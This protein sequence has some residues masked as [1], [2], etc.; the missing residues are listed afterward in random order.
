[1]Q[2]KPLN[3]HVVLITG[4]TQGIGWETAKCFAAEG[5]IVIVNGY[6]H[7]KLVQERSQ[8]LNNSYQ[9]ESMPLIADFSDPQ[10]IQAAYQT[11]YQQYKRLDIVVNNAGIMQSALLGMIDPEMVSTSLNLNVTGVIYSMQCAARL[12]RRSNKKGSIINVSSIMGRFG[13]EGQV[14]YSA[15]K[16]AV[17]GATMAAAKELASDGIR[18][19]CVAPGM[20][21]T[22]LLKDLS[23]DNRQKALNLIRLG[24]I[25]TPK[26]I[27]DAILFL[28]S[29]K[30]SYITGQTL[31]ID[32]GMAI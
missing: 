8:E 19:N 11:I 10:A 25:G 5:A 21:D 23:P 22:E 16:A 17:I 18:V 28:A 7:P 31:G 20:V 2:P 12:M 1:M 30:A 9:T 14:V 15:A 29:E 6:K 27:A 4:S 26:D 24:R 13:Y 32:G 3:E